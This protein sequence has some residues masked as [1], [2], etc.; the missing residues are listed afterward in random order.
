MGIFFCHAVPFIIHEYVV[1]FCFRKV[2]VVS[3]SQE[4]TYWSVDQVCTEASWSLRS[5]RETSHGMKDAWD[6]QLPG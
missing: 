4:M 2:L 5:K 6:G 1:T 3:H